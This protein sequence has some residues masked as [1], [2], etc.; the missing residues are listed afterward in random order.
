M[1]RARRQGAPTV[2]PINARGMGDLPEHARSRGA[3][4]HRTCAV[5]GRPARRRAKLQLALACWI[6][7]S[8]PS[9][10][11][12]AR[13]RCVPVPGP[14]A[15]TY[16]SRPCVV[17]VSSSP[18]A[19]GSIGSARTLRF[20]RGARRLPLAPRD[21]PLRRGGSNWTI[22]WSGKSLASSVGTG[23][24]AAR[25]RGSTR[26]L[27]LAAF[28]PVATTAGPW[29]QCSAR[30]LPATATASREDLLVIILL[31]RVTSDRSI[32]TDGRP[33]SFER[34]D[35]GAALLTERA[36]ARAVG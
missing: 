3:G 24:A 22:G 11:T 35:D 1:D 13:T 2:R 5:V 19:R 27:G 31:P 30:W 33:G 7:E 18:V 9:S 17:V 14:G 28:F 21:L 4:D 8:D 16:A 25:A 29:L 36:H 32:S 6:G 26:L 20:P 12:H 23:G 34:D 15:R 10:N